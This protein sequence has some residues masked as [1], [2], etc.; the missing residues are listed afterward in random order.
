MANEFL[1]QEEVD[2]LLSNV[3]GE[4]HGKPEDQPKES[5]S[6]YD[7]GRQERIV[8]GRMPTLE[9]I[10][11]RAARNL[12]Q[13]LYGLLR[14]TP[15]VA[16]KDKSIKPI[17]YS[18][19][20]KNLPVPASL[21]L[22]Q[23]RNLRGNG[24]IVL[25]P[26]LIFATIDSLFGGSGLHTRIEGRDFSPTEQ[27][28]IQ[29]LIKIITETFTLAWRPILP[30][31]FIPIRNEIHAQFA[32]IATPSEVVLAADFQVEIGESSG[33]IWICVPYSSIEP[34]RGL[35][36]NDLQNDTDRNDNHWGSVLRG[37]V[38]DSRTTLS[39]E[40]A[41]ERL[42]LQRVLELQVGDVLDIGESLQAIGYCN[43]VRLLK[44]IPG[45]R[46][47]HMA[48]QITAARKAHGLNL[49]IKHE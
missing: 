32:Q 39:F 27:Q 3:T 46:D 2:A 17:K 31:E 7:L 13:N 8:R 30:V 20:I 19:W 44:G 10:Y 45:E 14:K 22:I 16:L 21:T 35:L 18:E 37:H 11:D 6:A 42:P 5:I 49:G 48:V 15:E 29:R 34:I 36:T 28:V 23:L 9:I 33:V 1:S 40:I 38:S 12:R 25:D 43:G 47:G 4:E 41:R 26:S 24:L